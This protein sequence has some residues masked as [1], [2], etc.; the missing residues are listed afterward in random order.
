MSADKDDEINRMR[1]RMHD[2]NDVVQ[3]TVLR[4]ATIA[5]DVAHLVAGFKEHRDDSKAFMA[6]TAEELRAIREQTTKTNGRTTKLESDFAHLQS[7]VL[8]L[9]AYTPTPAAPPAPK[10]EAGESFSLGVKISPKMWVAA[11]AAG[12]M[13]FPKLIMW[14]SS[15][16]ERQ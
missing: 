7:D 2:L 4:H 14:L 11:A 3:A 15:L 9:R 10:A 16:L 6:D 12:G 5:S 13:L 1:E 8:N